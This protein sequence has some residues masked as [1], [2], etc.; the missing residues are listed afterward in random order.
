MPR[1]NYHITTWVMEPAD[2]IS[3]YPIISINTIPR[4]DSYLFEIYITFF[5]SRYKPCGGHCCPMHCDLFKIHCA[6]PNLGITRTWICRLNF[7]QRPIFQAWGSLKSL[8][9]QTR[10]L[11]LKVPPG[12]F[13]LRIFTS[14][15]NPSTSAGF[16]P[17]NL[18]YRGETTEADIKIHYSEW[19]SNTPLTFGNQVFII[20]L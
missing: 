7:A 5:Q 3:Q 18:G 13:V 4:T 8:K 15:K 6:P 10:D 16:E 14:W 12:G 1:H 17:A 19:Y 2:S 11:Q 20:V 9:S